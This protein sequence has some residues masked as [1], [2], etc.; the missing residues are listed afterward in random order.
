MRPSPDLADLSLA[1]GDRK[2]TDTHI[3]RVFCRLPANH[4]SFPLQ[5]CSLGGDDVSFRALL[6]PGASPAEA[7]TGAGPG[8]GT[9]Y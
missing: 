5:P 2:E 1:W 8:S 4:Y 3:I 7:S 6:P 9:V